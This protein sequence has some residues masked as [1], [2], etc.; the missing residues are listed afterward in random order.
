MSSSVEVPPGTVPPYVTRLLLRAG[1]AAGLDRHRLAG[2]DGLASLQDDAV[3]LPAASLVRIWEEWSAELR[4]LGGGP[5]PWQ[6]WRPGALGVWDYLFTSADTLTEAFE[7]ADH[8]AA[9]VTDPTESF[10]AVRGADG[11]TVSFHCRFADHPVFPIIGEFAAGMILTAAASGAGRPVTPT[12]V[13]LPGPGPRRYG[14]LARAYGTRS[15]EFGAGLPS[16]TF[17]TADADR[18]LPRADPALAAILRKHARTT[19]ANSRAVLCWFDRFRGEL[20]LHLTRGVPEL[21]RIAHTLNVSP[22][23]LQRRLQ[24][25][26]TS[27]RAE[28]ELARQHRVEQLLKTPL[29]VESIAARVGYAD[30]RSLSRAVHRW[31]GHGPA[32][33]RHARTPAATAGA[34]DGAERVPRA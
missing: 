7:H 16:V 31:Y 32:H 30:S 1:Q 19:L 2:V 8:H 3:R 17:S 22:R 26:G 23:T 15:I 24:E 21:A 25:E 18:P 4:D 14:H 27:W 12:R 13:V 11:L 20:E 5:L 10:A 28:L 34:A 29:S 33:L 9:A 6:L